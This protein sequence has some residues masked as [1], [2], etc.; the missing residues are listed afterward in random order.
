[1]SSNSFLLNSS[2]SCISD[3]EMK[4]DINNNFTGDTDI[5]ISIESPN[6]I[7]SECNKISTKSNIVNFIN[8][9][10]V[11]YPFNP[12]LNILKE[13]E[14]N[15][16]VIDTNNFLG[17]VNLLKKACNN[18]SFLEN[19][20]N[21]KN[22]LDLSPKNNTG[23]N[24]KYTISFKLEVIDFAKANG[25]N[26]TALKFNIAE[27]TVTYWCKR[28]ELYKKALNKSKRVTLH[29]GPKPKYLVIEEYLI[30]F[31]EFNRK[32]INPMTSW[33]LVTEMIKYIPALKEKNYKTL[34]EWI[35][36]FLS[37]NNYSFRRSTHVGHDLPEDSYNIICQ[38]ISQC[39]KSRV[40][41]KYT[42]DVIFNMDETPLSLNMPPNYTIAHKGKK[43]VIIRTQSQEKC[44]VSLILGIIADGNKLPPLIIF[45]GSNKTKIP[46]ELYNNKNI[47]EGKVFIA[48]N[49]NAWCT[50]D[51]MMLWNEKNSKK[52]YG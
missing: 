10:E 24:R 8:E 26:K 2:N 39:Y 30:N 9:N 31:I 5:K 27:S 36:R 18:I 17:E 29:Q 41:M 12:S 20:L 22:S 51:I 6:N 47:K 28:K 1:M 40:A 25:R 23:P 15:F 46:K 43:T 11:K 34:L 42:D 50:R 33:S 21:F 45:K 14:F 52:I 4:E 3:I 32:L 37:R 16:P 35:Y 49:E 13:N 19:D 7:T 48:F 44:R 38:F